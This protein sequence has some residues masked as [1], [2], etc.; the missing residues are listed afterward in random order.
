MRN[1]ETTSKKTELFQED[2]KKIDIAEPTEEETFEI[3]KGLKSHYEEHHGV[4][5][6]EEALRSAVHLSAKYITERFL[7]DKAIDVIDEAGAVVRLY[8]SD[9]PVVTE[10]NN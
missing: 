10:K 2:F 4:T 8:H 6:T 1:T 9:D 3:L 7:P 5:Y